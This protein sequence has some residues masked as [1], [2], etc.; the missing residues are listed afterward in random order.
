MILG[1]KMY[2]YA[3]IAAWSESEDKVYGKTYSSQLLDIF[4]SNKFK[5]FAKCAGKRFAQAAC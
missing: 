2:S 1:K 4:L 5:F 3:D